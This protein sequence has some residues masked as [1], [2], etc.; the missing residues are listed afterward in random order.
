MRKELRL[1]ANFSWFIFVGLINKRL[2]DLLIRL[3]NSD[4]R[5][6]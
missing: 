4:C 6:N 2:D 5:Y 3:V 1:T